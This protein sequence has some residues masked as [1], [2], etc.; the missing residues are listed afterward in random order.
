MPN[1]V[2]LTFEVLGLLMSVTLRYRTKCCGVVIGV[3]L[4]MNASTLLFS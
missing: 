4:N 3:T 2:K 1:F